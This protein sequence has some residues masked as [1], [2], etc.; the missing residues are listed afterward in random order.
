MNKRG[1]ESCTDVFAEVT[2]V[3]E[4]VASFSEC[5]TDRHAK[6]QKWRATT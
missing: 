5:S 3:R 6:T 4:W 1:D 2:G